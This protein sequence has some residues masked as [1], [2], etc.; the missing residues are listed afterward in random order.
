MLAALPAKAASSRSN[1][2]YPVGG[3]GKVISASA[4]TQDKDNSFRRKINR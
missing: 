1:S 2:S 3:V 4:C